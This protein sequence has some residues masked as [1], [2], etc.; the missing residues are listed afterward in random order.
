MVNS[1]AKHFSVH[2]KR[3]LT[4]NIT[5]GIYKTWGFACFLPLGPQICPCGIKFLWPY[6]K[7]AVG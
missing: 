5:Q 4:G 3:S 1:T 2:I 6:S 7:S